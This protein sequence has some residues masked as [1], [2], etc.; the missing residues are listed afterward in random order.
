MNAKMIRLSML[1]LL[2]TGPAL[3]TSCNV[4]GDPSQ[5]GIFWSERKAQGR[6]V[7]RQ[8]HLETIQEKT[9]RTKRQSRETKSRIDAL[10]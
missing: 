10:Q 8:D 5:G 3:T 2:G 7:E 6:L 9:A 1:I 4:T